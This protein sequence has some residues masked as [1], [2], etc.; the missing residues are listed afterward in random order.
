M[1][2]TFDLI[3]S[4]SDEDQTLEAVNPVTISGDDDDAVSTL[5]TT[6]TIPPQ[7]TPPKKTV[8]S[9]SPITLATSGH[10][11]NAVIQTGSTTIVLPVITTNRNGKQVGRIVLYL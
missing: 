3:F 2:L 10:V 5:T 9:S 8:A 11:Q 6:I 1:C 4:D 7:Q